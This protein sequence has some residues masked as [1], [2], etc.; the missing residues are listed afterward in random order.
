MVTFV[1]SMEMVIVPITS[2]KCDIH[3]A[4]VLV[5]GLG[6]NSWVVH[7]PLTLFSIGSCYFNRHTLKIFNLHESQAYIFP[8]E[9]YMV[10]KA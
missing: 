2:K 7:Q 9:K 4:F 1:I 8:H 10:L 3:V 5:C 6:Y